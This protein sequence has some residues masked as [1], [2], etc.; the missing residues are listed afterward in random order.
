MPVTTSLAP[1]AWAQLNV[2]TKRRYEWLLKEFGGFE[3]AWKHLD[4]GLLQ[5]FGCPEKTIER[6]LREREQVNMEE[7]ARTLEG[8][9]ITFLTLEDPRYPERLREITDPPLFLFAQ[10]DLAITKQPLIALV[11]TRKMS[12]YGKRATETIVADL[13]QAGVVTVSGLAIGIDAHVARETLRSSGRTIA[14]LG[15]GLGS[16]FPPSNTSLAEEIV[17]SGGLL[18]TEYPLHT[19]PDAFTFPARNRIIAGLTLGTVVLEAASQSGSLITASL[20]LEYGRE[21]FAVP[22]QIFDQNFDGTHE[23]I[24]KGGARLVRSA[25]D[26]LA[27]LGIVAG[28]GKQSLYR[29]QTPDEKVLLTVLCS[30]P[31]STDELIERSGLPIGSVNATLTLMELKGGAKNVG[32]G[33]WVKT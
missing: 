5:K 20:A 17:A 8:R 31:Q 27:E 26:V 7:V 21:V 9:S 14:V 1:L 29:A 6:V 25:A 13:V 3:A 11:G 28:E 16:I 22:G 18:L 23:L 15:H 12:T 32:G 2:L 24:A 10:G 4:R 30:M 19:T 33:L